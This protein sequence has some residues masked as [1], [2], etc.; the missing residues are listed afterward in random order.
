MTKWQSRPLAAMSLWDYDDLQKALKENPEDTRPK[1]LKRIGE[2]FTKFSENETDVDLVGETVILLNRVGAWSSIN[3]GDFVQ[4][5]QRSNKKTRKVFFEELP[6]ELAA[7]FAAALQ[8]AS[9]SKNSEDRLRIVTAARLARKADR[10]EAGE[11]GVHVV[12]TT[13]S[14][15]RRS[16]SPLTLGEIV[17]SSGD[18]F[19]CPNDFFGKVRIHSDEPQAKLR[20]VENY[21]PKKK[22]KSATSQHIKA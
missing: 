8:R 7:S 1:L 10:K 11:R 21:E 14:K 2:F 9:S 22:K 4:V 19:R 16:A 20:Y 3:P 6:G 15:N 18:I 12:S 5:L 17:H 13:I